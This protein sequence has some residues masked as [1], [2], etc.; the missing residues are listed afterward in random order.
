MAQIIREIRVDVSQPNVFQAIVAKQLDCNSRFLKITLVDFGVKIEVPETAKVTIN[1]NRPD[2]KSQ[3]FMGVA[4]NDGTITVPLAQWMLEVAGEL[5][6][7]VSVIN[8]TDNKRLTSTDFYVNV[9]EAANK[10]T[11]I[12]ENPDGEIRVITPTQ[13][14]DENSS[15]DE[16]PSAKAVYDLDNITASASGSAITVDSAS[17][18]LQNLKLFGK[19]EQNGTP[20]PDAPV[21]L[22]SV[23]DSGSFDAWLCGKNIFDGIFE[24][25]HAQHNSVVPTRIR[26]KNLI[27][28]SK[29]KKYTITKYN[30]TNNIFV[31]CVLSNI[32]PKSYPLGHQCGTVNEWCYNSSYSF[33]ATNDGVLGFMVKRVDET[34]LSPTDLQ[35]IQFQV[36]T[37]DSTEYEPCNK[38][39]LTMPYTLPSVTGVQDEIDFAKGV[40]FNKVGVYKSLISNVD[41]TAN[42]GGLFGINGISNFKTLAKISCNMFVMGDTRTTNNTI[43][44]DRG[45]TKQPHFKCDGFETV[46][47][48]KS[49]YGD[50]EIVIHYELETPQEIPLT[51]T[52]LNAYRHLMTNKGNTTFISEAEAEVDYYINK[53]NAQAIGNIHTQVNADYFKLQQAI[54]TTGGS[55]L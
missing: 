23:G 46:D 43:N 11:D 13:K 16:Y 9:Q 37:G 44:T 22:V 24:Q 33:V 52:E 41:I 48:F 39:T 2:G 20:T 47:D 25:G 19:T 36:E 30:D 5:K 32:T 4:N 42:G 7:D 45:T 3:S 12:S 54:I 21:P 38:Q 29:G 31:F 34:D 6:C 35:N 18:P 55:T 17:A 49:A 14:I 50:K 26:I 1:A 8:T 28:I 51:E 53:P 40:R 15:D 27:P 10:N